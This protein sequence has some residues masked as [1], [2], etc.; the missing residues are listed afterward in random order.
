MDPEARKRHAAFIGL[1][2]ALL[3]SLPIWAVLTAALIWLL[4]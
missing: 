3:I 2:N 4:A 1:R